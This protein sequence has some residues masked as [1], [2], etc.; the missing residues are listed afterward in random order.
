MPGVR[1]FLFGSVLGPSALQSHSVRLQGLLS[2]ENTA[3]PVLQA[4]KTILDFAPLLS[5][6]PSTVKC[7]LYYFECWT[8]REKGDV[9]TCVEGRPPGTF[10]SNASTFPS[11]FRPNEVSM[12]TTGA[13]DLTGFETFSQG[14][15]RGRTHRLFGR[16]RFVR[17]VTPRLE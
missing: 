4:V 7:G 14:L 2:P 15:E 5:S 9:R 11:H 16:V 17:E 6:L 10:R 8:V 13:S 3:A 1:M 12:R